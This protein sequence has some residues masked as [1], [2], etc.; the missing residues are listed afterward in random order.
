MSED[1]MTPVT[2]SPDPNLAEALETV[3]VEVGALE[4]TPRLAPGERLLRG[5][6]VPTFHRQAAIDLFLSE[7]GASIWLVSA[8][9]CS[10]ACLALTRGRAPGAASMEEIDATIEEG[11]LS[12]PGRRSAALRLSALP[13]GGRLPSILDEGIDGIDLAAVIQEPGRP[14]HGFSAWG[15]M[16]DERLEHH[17]V[18]FRTLLEAAIDA[19]PPSATEACQLEGIAR[20]LRRLSSPDRPGA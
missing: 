9:G 1:T 17:R 2:S 4:A 11:T 6:Y 3:L 18:F 15:P 12:E 14:A 19:L 5:L 8:E 10:D 13:D 16:E 20:Y 7:A